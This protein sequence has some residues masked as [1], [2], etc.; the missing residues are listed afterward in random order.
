M[1]DYFRKLFRPWGL[2][3]RKRRAVAAV[4]DRR[5]LC[6]RGAP[7]RRRSEI[8]ATERG[9]WRPARVKTLF[10][11]SW[12]KVDRDRRSHQPSRAGGPTFCLSWG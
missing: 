7:R 3:R 9:R 4:S 8:A 2:K 5:T 10:S 11:F 1:P 12:E 6:A